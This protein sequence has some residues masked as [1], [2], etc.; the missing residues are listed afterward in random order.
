MASLHSAT[1]WRPPEIFIY[2]NILSRMLINRVI[3]ALVYYFVL[4]KL[5]FYRR[6]ACTLNPYRQLSFWHPFK[7]NHYGVQ[8]IFFTFHYH[9]GIHFVYL[10]PLR[11]HFAVLRR[12]QIYRSRKHRSC[13][14]SFNFKAVNT[15]NE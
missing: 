15:L 2:I 14:F 6:Y 10:L 5:F 13:L 12:C 11:Y 8:S 4:R 7:P 3:S 9:F 1:F